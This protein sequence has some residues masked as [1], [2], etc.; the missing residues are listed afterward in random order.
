MVFDVYGTLDGHI[1]KAAPLISKALGYTETPNA[2]QKERIERAIR[3]LIDYEVLYPNSDVT[4]RKADGERRKAD[5][6][7]W[8][9]AP[10]YSNPHP[11]QLIPR[12]GSKTPAYKYNDNL[13]GSN[14]PHLTGAEL[15][16]QREAAGINLRDF[17]K[18]FKKSIR[19]WS[20]FENEIILKR[21]GEPRRLDK[22]L[23]LE[24]IDYFKDREGV[25]EK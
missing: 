25:N 22:V 12:T 18:R 4:P 15:K 20:E 21:T 24:I 9:R 8:R 16:E 11:K 14:A 2:R 6:Y 7:V 23:E 13:F 17:A 10:E 5:Y 19:F 1:E 3:V